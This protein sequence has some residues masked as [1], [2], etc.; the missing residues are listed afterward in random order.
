MYHDNGGRYGEAEADHRILRRMPLLLRAGPPTGDTA[1][2]DQSGPVLSD[3]LYWLHQVQRLGVA[4]AQTH[5]ALNGLPPHP[6]ASALPPWRGVL[7]ALGAGTAYTAGLL[8]QAVDKTSSLLRT[9]GRRAPWDDA[10]SGAA[11]VRATCSMRAESAICA[12]LVQ[13]CGPGLIA[14][15]AAK[16]G[17]QAQNVFQAMAGADVFGAWR[18]A[19]DPLYL[20]WLDGD[21]RSFNAPPPLFAHRAA[22]YTAYPALATDSADDEPLSNVD[23]LPIGSLERYVSDAAGS[24]WAIIIAVPGNPEDPRNWPNPSAAVLASSAHGDA[25]P[26]RCYLLAD[27]V[28]PHQVLPLITSGRSLEDIAG[29]LAAAVPPVPAG[30]L[31]A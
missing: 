12:E 27:M 6:L 26:G 30:R 29:F 31:G 2:T 19:M 22:L 7:E 11:W 18:A 5:T 14:D 10:V 20:A 3:A 21:L 16:L 25:S 28:T 8:Q 9:D 24:W 17:A 4:V 15:R 13:M 1:E 23:V